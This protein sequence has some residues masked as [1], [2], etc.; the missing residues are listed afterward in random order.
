M[1]ELTLY[2]LVL[3]GDDVVDSVF[4]SIGEDDGADSV[5]TSTGEDDGVDSVFISTGDDDGVDCVFISI[6]DSRCQ[7]WEEMMEWTQQMSVLEG[8]DRVHFVD[9]VRAVPEHSREVVGV[10]RV[11][12]FDLVTE[13]PMLGES[14]HF[15]V[16]IHHLAENGEITYNKTFF[17]KDL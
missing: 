3:K 9:M 13:P 15:P 16:V 10:W 17:F 5:F 14:V 6:D 8:D 11:V 12:H 4:I 1:T 7:Y 2:S